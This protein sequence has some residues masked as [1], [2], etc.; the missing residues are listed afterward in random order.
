MYGEGDRKLI[1]KYHLVAGVATF[2]G[3]PSVQIFPLGEEKKASIKAQLFVK[4]EEYGNP[5]PLIFTGTMDEIRE[6]LREWCAK[7]DFIYE[8]KDAE[9]NI[10]QMIVRAKH[11]M[12]NKKNG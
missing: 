10:L 7:N 8:E 11:S 12:E 9:N 4:F 1:P 2:T 3:L 6:K 5:E